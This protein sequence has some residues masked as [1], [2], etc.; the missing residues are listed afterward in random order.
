MFFMASEYVKF[1]KKVMKQLH[2]QHFSQIK[3]VNVDFTPLEPT[4]QLF[5]QG[6]QRERG[7]RG[8]G[9]RLRMRVE[10]SGSGWILG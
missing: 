10:G 7:G 5:I 9:T 1:I 3:A 4:E 2:N 6:E 8:S